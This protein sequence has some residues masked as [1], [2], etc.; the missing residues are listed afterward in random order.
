MFKLTVKK[1]LTAK[2]AFAG[3]GR[4]FKLKVWDEEGKYEN[5]Y[6]MVYVKSTGEYVEKWGKSLYARRHKTVE[7]LKSYA[8]YLDY[9]GRNNPSYREELQPDRKS[10]REQKRIMR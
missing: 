8:G 3:P 9:M 10:A 6:V 7:N 5:K 2:N 4:K 1:D